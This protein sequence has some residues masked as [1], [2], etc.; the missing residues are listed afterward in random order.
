MESDDDGEL[1]DWLMIIGNKEDHNNILIQL[2]KK[3]VVIRGHLFGK[4]ILENIN[5]HQ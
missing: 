1:F 3:W 2:V 4:S 5:K